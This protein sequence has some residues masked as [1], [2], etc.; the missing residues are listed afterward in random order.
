MIDIVTHILPTADDGARNIKETF[1]LIQE[2]KEA[3]FTDLILTSTYR[4]DFFELDSLERK[5]LMNSILINIKSKGIGMN[6]YLGNKIYYDENIIELIKNMYVSPLN[7][8]RYILIEMPYDIKEDKINECIVELLKNNFIPILASVEKYKFVQKNPNSLIKYINM[9]VLMQGNFG[10]II[11]I[12]G[13]KEEKTIIKML[14]NNLIHFL[15][16]DV[17][18]SKTIYLKINEILDKLKTIIPKEEIDELTTVNPRLVIEDEIIDI[19]KP[20]QIKHKFLN[21]F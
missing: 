16:T 18:Y 17:Y 15:A 14:E 5:A 1:D 6:L 10:S 7:N 2:A 21:I 20:L 12:E 11:G 4:K 19:R 9:G 13:K 3:G 8:T